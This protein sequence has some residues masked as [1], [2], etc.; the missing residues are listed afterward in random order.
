MNACRR[1]EMRTRAAPLHGAGALPWALHPPTTPPPQRA[2]DTGTEEGSGALCSVAEKHAPFLHVQGAS[3]WARSYEG[4]NTKRMM[5]SRPLAAVS[6]PAWQIIEFFFSFTFQWISH[7]HS[8]CV[9]PPARA[10]KGVW[11]RCATNGWPRTG[12]RVETLRRSGTS[13]ER[14]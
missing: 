13:E 12:A 9:L 7:C 8:D 4:A 2:K 10:P 5:S 3:S 11:T 14:T 1:A 6:L